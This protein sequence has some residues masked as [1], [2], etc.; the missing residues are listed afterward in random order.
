MQIAEGE[1]KVTKGSPGGAGM[2]QSTWPCKARKESVF[3]SKIKGV[4]FD[5]SRSRGVSPSD[6]I[7]NNCSGNYMKKVWGLTHEPGA[8]EPPIWNFTEAHKAAS[9]VWH[10]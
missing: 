3:Y 1:G 2:S 6:C 5:L 8:L 4:T 10:T 7:L 9:S